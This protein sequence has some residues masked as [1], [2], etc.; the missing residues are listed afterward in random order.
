MLQII[1]ISICTIFSI[2]VHN[3]ERKINLDSDIKDSIL[4]S[5]NNLDYDSGAFVGISVICAVLGSFLVT[6]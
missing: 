2:F 3:F 1:S 6:H 5:L 4:D